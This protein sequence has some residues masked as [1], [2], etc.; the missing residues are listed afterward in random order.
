MNREEEIR[1]QSQRKSLAQVAAGLRAWHA[2][3]V[4]ILD[5]EEQAT[6]PPDSADG[7]AKILCS[8]SNGNSA[9]IKNAFL[10]FH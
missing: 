3:A 5:Y 9:A 6:I 2:F 10:W 7:V 4:T 8:F 1:L